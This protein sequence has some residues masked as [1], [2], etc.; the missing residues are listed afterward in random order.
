M[1]VVQAAIDDDA[2]RIATALSGGGLP[3]CPGDL[4]TCRGELATYQADL[5]ACQGGSPRHF[6]ATGQRTCW[7]SSGLVIV[8][9]GTGHDGEIQAGAA[10]AYV[11]NGDGT[12]TDVNTGLMWKSCL[13]T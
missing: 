4:S 1:A 3:T 13:T 2:T 11:D 9:E 5:A 7:N 10:L 6:P 12:I 8:C